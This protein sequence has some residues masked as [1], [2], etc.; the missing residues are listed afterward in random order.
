[1]AYPF[2][3]LLFYYQ[4]VRP[5]AP[6]QAFYLVLFLVQW[7]GE[8]I[9]QVISLQLNQS[10]QLAGGVAA[11]LFTMLSGSFPLLPMSGPFQI[12]SSFSF[13]RW[14]M[15]GLVSVEY[16][17]WFLGD[18][19]YAYFLDDTGVQG[20][21]AYG[22]CSPLHVNYSTWDIKFSAGPHLVTDDQTGASD[23]ATAKCFKNTML[24]KKLTPPPPPPP[25]PLPPPQLPAPAPAYPEMLCFPSSHQSVAT[26]LAS[27]GYNRWG[28]TSNTVANY[29]LAPDSKLPD[30]AFSSFGV[31]PGFSFQACSALISIGLIC[32][33]LTCLL[34]MCKD[35]ARRR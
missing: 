19:G 6:F 7:V 27:Y 35:K 3:M 12:L 8:G 9:G 30:I 31:S 25:Q 33:A 2:F 13:V 1:M 5:Y 17:P 18:P 14:G 22:G 20:G 21:N 26:L 34:L 15:E 29:Q 4:K 10:R 16:A 24:D 28:A 32:R 23:A 11:L